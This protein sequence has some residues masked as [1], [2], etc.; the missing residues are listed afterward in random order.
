MTP[1][2]APDTMSGM[3]Q[4]P[5][6]LD[7]VARLAQ[8]V[9]TLS[10]RLQQVGHELQ[11]AQTAQSARS[12]ADPRWLTQP[13]PPILPRSVW[14]PVPAQGAPR[15]A[16]AP[17]QPGY[18]PPRPPQ[19]P[20]PSR[21][22]P[23]P[24]FLPPLLP[25]PPAGPSWWRREGATSRVLAIAGSVITLLG[26]VMF[27]VLAVQ[28][29]YLGPVPRVIGGA[30]LACTFIGT[31]FPLH[32][33]Q[34]GVEA[35]ALAATGTAGLY[36]DVVAA[37]AYY[38]WVPTWAGLM[39][40]FAI[41]AGG[42]VLADRW[43]SET[44]SVLAVLGAAALSPA[45]TGE[46][47]ATLTSFL[48]A[49]SVAAGLS[50]LR[51]TWRVLFTVRSV[52]PV[53]AAALSLTTVDATSASS[54]WLTVLTCVLVTAGGVGFGLHALHKVRTDV[55]A[56]AMMSLSVAPTLLSAAVLDRWAAT[57]VIAGLAVALLAL[58]SGVR[59]LPRGA[60][61][62]L[63]VAG[64]VAA[65]EAICIAGTVDSRSALLLIGAIGLTTVAHRMRSKLALVLAVVYA[66]L[67]T[68]LLLGQAPP[69]VA[70][71]ARF[72]ERHSSWPAVLAGVL[73]VVAAAVVAY[74][75]QWSGVLGT[76]PVG[77]VLVGVAALYGGTTAFVSAGV[78]LPIADGFV[79]G[80]TTATITW[81]VAAMV[82]L[83][84]GLSRARLAIVAIV[85][86]V[87]GLALAAAAVA[88]LLL[89][90]LAALDGILRVSGFIVVGL[91][92]IAAGTRYAKAL[93]N[94][95]AHA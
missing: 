28:N 60:Q 2:R 16:A 22:S 30:V 53:L 83:G 73:L 41:A 31:A 12:A 4:H 42:L 36:L 55:L 69:M 52:V 23:P 58:R 47:D 91:L 50:Q 95:T 65:F 94:N 74:E 43:S 63:I 64:A 56:L 76:A 72:A 71:S 67:G 93:A 20:Q 7:T 54:V 33:R 85:A 75:V 82:L 18:L 9:V 89:F 45:L 24:G 6:Q 29:G 5:G 39:L 57:A 66:A 92:L 15:A 34:G 49:L 46:P 40:G 87:A 10:G 25:L 77:W 68:L 26:V 61:V 1:R 19:V 3:T 79:A 8:E 13:V 88:K 17:S 81:M 44:L 80:H 51:H 62:V 27:L 90:D 11:A 84:K 35:I 70:I 38:G 32:K 37:T 78:L 21:Q 48:L 59:W 14:G 86:R